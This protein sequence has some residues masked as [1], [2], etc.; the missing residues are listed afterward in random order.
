MEFFR[1]FRYKVLLS[2]NKFDFFLLDFQLSFCFRTSRTMLNRY[3]ESGHP[4]LLPD[5]DGNSLSFS[6]FRMLWTCY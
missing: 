5:F 4:C 1:C 3:G 2:A 6:P